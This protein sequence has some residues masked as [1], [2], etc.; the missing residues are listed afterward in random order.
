L[1]ALK[2]K[3][4]LGPQDAVPAPIFVSGFKEI[5]QPAAAAHLASPFFSI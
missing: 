5:L 1:D 4:G 2:Q 3:W